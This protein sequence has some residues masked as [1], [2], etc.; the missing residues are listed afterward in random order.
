MQSVVIIFTCVAA[1]LLVMHILILNSK[2]L[3]L[4]DHPGGRKDHPLVT[5]LVGG[6]SIAVVLVLSLA[7]LMPVHAMAMSI[8]II[9]LMA[10]GVKDDI[11]EVSPLPKLAVQAC[12]CLV[13]IFVGHVELRSV[14]NLL[15]LG[16][17]GLWIFVIPMTI[18]ASIGVINA[19][20]MADGMDGHSGIIIVVALIAYAFVAHDSG[21]WDQYQT[22]LVLIGAMF[23]FLLLN[24]RTPWRK[25]A[26]VFLGDAGSMLMGFLLAWFA[27]DLSSSAHG[28]AR[29]F[30]PICALWVVVIPLCDCVSLM[31]RRLMARVSPLKADRQHLH[32]FLLSRGL[33]VSQANLLM[34]M[35]STICAA[36]GVGG[37]KWGVPQPLLFAGFV[38]LFVVYHFCISRYFSAR[39]VMTT[40]MGRDAF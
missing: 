7:W 2:K 36:V 32:H 30:P 26:A 25:R 34:L 8:A 14:G 13:M 4:L 3:K 29:P 5:P 9:L 15:G 38:A 17:I 21:L 6:I 20:N 10:I 18:F 35:V 33:S 1:T 12:A 31:V 37:W 28:L 39:D 40:A 27:I 11:H 16:D 23:A 24:L 22:L 19:I